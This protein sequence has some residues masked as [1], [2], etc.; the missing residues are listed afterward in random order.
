MRRIL[1]Q[2]VGMQGLG[3]A[4]MFGV[5]LLV[6]RLGG[7]ESQGN[8]ALVK[9]ATDLQVAIFSF[10]LP[11]AIVFLLNRT[12]TG[13]RAAFRLSLLYGLVLVL[14][15][16]LLDFVLLL[17]SGA[18]TGLPQ[19][20]AHAIGIGLASA[21]MTAL[22]LLR[23]L[24]LV[25]DDGPAFSS[26]S[27]LQWAVIALVAVLLLNR[28]A[29][30]F[31]LAYLIAGIAS[32]CAVLMLLQ[33]T[34]CYRIQESL[35]KNDSGSIVD[36]GI[37]WP[38]IRSQS[39]NVLLQA[40]TLGLQPFLSN[41]L[42]SRSEHGSVDVGLFNVASMVVVIPNLLVALVAPVLYN[43]WS[44][45]LEWAGLS[46]IVRNALWLGVAAQCLTLLAMPLV[47]PVILLVFGEPF[48]AAAT[49][50][51]VLLLATLPIIAG[52][53]VSPALQGIGSTLWVS[54]SCIVR[55]VVAI[56]LTLAGM[57]LDAS[58]ILA[59]AAAWCAGEYAALAVLLMKSLKPQASR[60]FGASI[61]SAEAL[62]N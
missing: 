40:V 58:P 22:A 6:S 47:E 62:P 49:A 57:G 55:L 15:L 28:S 23:G 11:P 33:R 34:G 52:R 32:L 51:R 60:T 31:E 43:R 37:N 44:K 53:I 1:T 20:A 2:T 24:L 29:Y 56:S 17:A 50:T 4:L 3:V 21:A 35:T 8:F 5:T 18:V 14:V 45:T 27:I 36:D 12:G 61:P 13:H 19:I 16:P 41:L 9:S 59:L 39:G 48:A 54:V 25:H 38:I 26:L 42:L 7:P 46:K 30:V 10:G